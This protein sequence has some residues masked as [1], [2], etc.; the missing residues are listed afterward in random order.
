MNS[1]HISDAEKDTVNKDREENQQLSYEIKN[2]G[3]N[4]EIE[5]IYEGGKHREEGTEE[6]AVN[7]EQV[8]GKENVKEENALSYCPKM[9]FSNSVYCIPNWSA[10]PAFPFSLEIIKDGAL[11]GSHDV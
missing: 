11:I 1:T 8:R 5:T 7:K 10:T 6:K 3:N 2:H 4:D 9:R